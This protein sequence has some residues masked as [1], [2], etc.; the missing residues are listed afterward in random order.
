MPPTPV[1]GPAPNWGGRLKPEAVLD[2]WRSPTQP[3]ATAEE[4]AAGAAQD[5]ANAFA[6]FTD[7]RRWLVW[8]Q[9]VRNGKPTKV[10][11]SPRTHRRADP[12]DLNQCGTRSEAEAFA[13]TLLNGVAGGIGIAL[14]DLGDGTCL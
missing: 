11:Y 13:K 9:E 10:P 2:Q 4:Q 1:F 6:M 7:A 8:R 5:A 14:G 12:T 3:G